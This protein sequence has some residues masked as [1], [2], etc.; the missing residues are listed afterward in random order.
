MNVFGKQRIASKLKTRFSRLKTFQI[1]ET[2][3]TKK[4][5]ENKVQKAY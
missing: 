4:K 1:H 2:N 5:T 3:G